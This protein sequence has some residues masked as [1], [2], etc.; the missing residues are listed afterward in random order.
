[1]QHHTEVSFIIPDVLEASPAAPL[2]EESHR[3]LQDGI[4]NTGKHAPLHLTS[5]RLTK[6]K[7]RTCSASNASIS[8]QQTQHHPFV[9]RVAPLN[10]GIG[11][12]SGAAFCT[13]QDFHAFLQQGTPTGSYRVYYFPKLLGY[14]STGP[15]PTPASF[16]A[17]DFPHSVEIEAVDTQQGVANLVLWVQDRKNA[18]AL[19]VDIIESFGKGAKA[20]ITSADIAVTS[21]GNVVI[22]LLKHKWHAE[23]LLAVQP[24]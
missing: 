20:A 21:T 2:G 23:F 3:S 6:L 8:M 24:A 11:S 9:H 22:V 17:A 19:I 5:S 15:N 12:S 14:G 16:V 7:C 1:M 10:A 18:T 13:P 4:D